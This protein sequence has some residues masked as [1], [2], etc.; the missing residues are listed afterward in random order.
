ML[1]LD[2]AAMLI[3]TKVNRF[4]IELHPYFNIFKIEVIN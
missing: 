3:E 1:T 2:N 4:H